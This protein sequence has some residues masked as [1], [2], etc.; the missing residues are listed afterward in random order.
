MDEKFPTFGTNVLPL[1]SGVFKDTL[2]GFL[3]RDAVRIGLRTT[4]DV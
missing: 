3:Y 4:V 1:F 2:Y